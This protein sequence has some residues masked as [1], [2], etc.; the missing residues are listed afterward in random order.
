[1][2]KEGEVGMTDR[3]KVIN[4]LVSHIESALSIDSDFVDCVRTDLLQT[5]VGLLKKQT[6]SGWVSDRTECDKPPYFDAY[7]VLR[8]QCDDCPY[9][10]VNGGGC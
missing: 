8:S 9:N 7:K 6:F 5:A 2:R 3:E 4:E 1:M 10:P